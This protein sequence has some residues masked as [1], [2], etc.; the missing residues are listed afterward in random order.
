MICCETC[1]EWFHFDC[2]DMTIPFE[3]ASEI[4][5]KCFLCIDDKTK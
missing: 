3:E 4:D 5:F 2:L 1:D